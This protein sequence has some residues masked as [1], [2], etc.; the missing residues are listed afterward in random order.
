MSGWAGASAAIL[1]DRVHCIADR[2][3]R[4]GRIAFVVDERLVCRAA[5][6]AVD[7]MARQRGEVILLAEPPPPAVSV[8]AVTTA[9]RPVPE[10][11]QLD[12]LLE[13]GGHLADIADELAHLRCRVAVLGIEEELGGARF[14]PAWV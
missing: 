8:P 2:P 5:D 3:A 9:G 10:A 4:L 11:C 1:A 14:A 6:G 13:F 12:G 7:T